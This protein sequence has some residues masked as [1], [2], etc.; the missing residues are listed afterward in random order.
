LFLERSQNGGKLLGRVSLSVAMARLAQNWEDVGET[1]HMSIF[2]H[3]VEKTQFA[4]K[5]DR[6][7][8][9][10]VHEDLRSFLY[11]FHFFLE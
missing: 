11:R 4:L 7:K 1:L 6:N 2:R 5:P 9:Y 10:F 3:P 8:A